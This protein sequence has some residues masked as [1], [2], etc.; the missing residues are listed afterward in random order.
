VS[1]GDGNGNGNKDGD[2]D[3]ND[4]CRQQRVTATRVAGKQ[5]M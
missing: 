4:G 3:G 5:L 1:N 2:G